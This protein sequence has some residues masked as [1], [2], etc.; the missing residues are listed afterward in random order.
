MNHDSDR[1]SQQIQ[2]D[3]E[4]RR[5]D[6]DRTLTLLE[7]RLQPRRLVDQGIDY[8]RDH[9]ASEYLSNLG[10]ATREQPLPLALVGVGLAWLMM[11]N[12]RSAGGSSSRVDGRDMGEAMGD[13]A[14]DAGSRVGQAADAI[15]SRAGEVGDAV[16]HAMSQTRDAA[17]RTSQT[18]S[19]AAS[20]T[21]ARAAQLGDATRQGAQ[22]LRSGYDQLVNEQPLA[23]GAIGLA[24]GAVLAATAPRTR[25][26]DEWM[27]E[28]SDKLLDD[29][30]RAGHEKLRE[31]RDVVA[32]TTDRARSEPASAWPH[33]PRQS[34]PDR[35]ARADERQGEES[36]VQMP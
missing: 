17:Q 4:R 23:L 8:L 21:R 28:A 33:Q 16:S 30:K 24:L 22:K 32:E 29:A 2:A 25:P 19:D 7:G 15:R 6:L 26:E 14:A 36:G 12:G 31:V 1:S 34:E 13:S 27:G 18:L 9:G 35:T 20:A 10:R 11:T 3:I 5:S